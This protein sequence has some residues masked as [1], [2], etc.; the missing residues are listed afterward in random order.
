MINDSCLICDKKSP[1]I[2]CAKCHKEY[3][4]SSNYSVRFARAT[5]RLHREARPNQFNYYYDE[6]WSIHRCILDSLKER[7]KW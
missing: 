4:N 6:D 2:M 7:E 5:D 1:T 3:V